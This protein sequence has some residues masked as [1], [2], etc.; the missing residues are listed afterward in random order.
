[1]WI[2]VLEEEYGV[3][4]TADDEVPGIILVLK[5]A[6]SLDA[7]VGRVTNPFVNAANM[8]ANK[9]SE[10]SIIVTMLLATVRSNVEQDAP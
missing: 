4:T 8:N 6:W 9:G 1:M 2:A 3:V 5:I 10:Y 7:D